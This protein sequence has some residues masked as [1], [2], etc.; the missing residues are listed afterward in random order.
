MNRIVIIGNGFD[1]AQGLKT[2]Y[3]HFLLDYFK[4]EIRNKIEDSL[5]ESDKLFQVVE[6]NT[7]QR[8]FSDKIEK[9]ENLLQFKSEVKI[10]FEEI[11]DAFTYP[12]TETKKNIKWSQFIEIRTKS[13]FFKNLIDTNN[14]TDI[15]KFYF[16]ELT[17][18]FKENYNNKKQLKKE[19]ISLNQDF[20]HLKLMLVEYLKKIEYS[21]EKLKFEGILRNSFKPAE[22]SYY[23]NF[24]DKSIK[25]KEPINISNVVYL[26]FNYTNTLD[27]F[28]KKFEHPY[29]RQSIHCQIHG[30]IDEPDSIIF[31]F[32]DDA[33][34][35]K[36]KDLE[37]ADI[38]ELLENIKSIHYPKTKQ[39]KDLMNIVES[40]PFDVLVLGHS[41]G[42]SDRVLLESIFEN[43]NCKSIRLFHRGNKRS[44]ED[45][46]IA[47][48]RHFKNKQSMRRKIVYNPD[49][50]LGELKE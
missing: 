42:L 18:K 50:V 39:Y 13:I 43:D 3:E 19:I 24:F 5:H 38:R 33:S 1:L 10:D 21:S 7:D 34:N 47:I 28:F 8:F 23:R 25:S 44:F 20:E 16:E 17:S 31:G 45:K 37:D 29:S 14:W 32:G 27:N 26:N 12:R 35:A 30:N 48:S 36:Y 22:L 2:K 40:E 9:I 49:D 4:T 46:V 41:L 6:Q 15:E 11:D